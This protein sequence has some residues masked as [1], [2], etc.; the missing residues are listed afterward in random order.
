MIRFRKALMIRFP[1]DL[2]TG[3]DFF[4][5]LGLRLQSPESSRT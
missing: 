3:S 1:Q 4:V 5:P 2:D